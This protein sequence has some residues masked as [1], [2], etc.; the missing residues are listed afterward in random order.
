MPAPLITLTTDFGQADGYV[1][2]MKGVILSRAAHAHIIDLSHEI[3]PQDIAA[4]AFVLYRAY[5]YFPPD[6]IHVAVVDPGVGTN[7]RAVLLVTDWGRFVGPDNG[8]FSYVLREAIALAAG[9]SGT[10][11]N[12]PAV[13][14]PDFDIDA[15]LATTPGEYLPAAYVLN[16]PSYWLAGAGTSLG[17]TFQGRDLF[18][19]VAA[20]LAQNVAPADLGQSIP[21]D[22]LTLLPAPASLLAPGVIEGRV[23]SID[24]FGNLV[25]NIAAGLLPTLGPLETLQISL[26][27]QQLRGIHSTYATTPQGAPLA[28]INS[29]GLLEIAIREGSAAQRFGARVG[30]AVACSSKSG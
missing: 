13:W 4:G 6:T 15:A 16:N 9:W 26:G 5:R 18:A 28:L 24:H 23:I 12:V 3:A 1:G 17:A 30:D 27:T 10:P 14:H 25:S 19:P 21:L 22:S 8:L 29:A 7:R 20:H 11:A 2:T